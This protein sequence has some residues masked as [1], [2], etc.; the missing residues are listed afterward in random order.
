MFEQYKIHLLIAGLVGSIAWL[1][2][3]TPKQIKAWF[4]TVF[5]GVAFAWYGGEYL[6]LKTGIPEGMAGCLIGFSTQFIVM[7]GIEG[8]VPFLNKFI[9]RKGE[10]LANDRR[11]GDRHDR[12]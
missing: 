3:T 10:D 4:S 6:A 1:G 2:I 7:A 11:K 9:R 8:R 5:I 12:H